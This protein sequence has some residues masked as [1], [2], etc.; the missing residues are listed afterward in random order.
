MSSFSS[1]VICT[2]P[3]SGS[4]LLCSLLAS[5]GIAGKPESYF[6]R[7]SL[8][9]W[10]S[11]LDVANGPEIGTRSVRDLFAGARSRGSTSNGLFGLRLQR[12]SFAFLF[13]TLSELH[14]EETSERAR[15]ERVFGPTLFIH[16]TREDKLAQ[17]ISCVR[18]QQ[19]GL[20]H[21]AA[22]GSELERS[23]PVSEPHYDAAAIASELAGFIEADRLWTD[24]FSDEQIDPVTVRYSELSVAPIQA[25]RRL[26][27][28][29]DLDPSDSVA[30]T[31]GTRRLSDDLN[32]EWAERF[33]GERHAK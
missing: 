30:V 25:T 19:S 14:P 5:T 24:W 4:T 27:H 11:A 29:L 22:D 10:A 31:A 28:A 6:H 23:T 13:H 16:L 3:R 33:K 12:D 18:A 32:T 1:Y 2:S 8:A 26:L 15:F 21:V 20:W 9:D 17:A 7:P